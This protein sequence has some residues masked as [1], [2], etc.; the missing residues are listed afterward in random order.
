MLTPS[1]RL[2]GESLL[3]A[4]AVATRRYEQGYDAA[5][6]T[7]AYGNPCSALSVEP[8]GGRGKYD[9]NKIEIR[10]HEPGLW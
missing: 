3:Y 4:L 6:L 2:E 1:H 10:Y 5:K 8:V 9:R 7:A